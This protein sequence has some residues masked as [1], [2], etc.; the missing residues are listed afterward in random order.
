MRA[1]PQLTTYFEIQESINRLTELL[2]NSTMELSD[3]AMKELMSKLDAE[4]ERL[5]KEAHGNR[6]ISQITSGS[7]AG[8]WTAHVNGKCIRRKT[9]EQFIDAMFEAYYPEGVTSRITFGECFEQMLDYRRTKAKVAEL[10]V[11]H[12]QSDYTKY[13]KGTDL[14]RKLIRE[15]KPRDIIH[16]VDD[17]TGM[18]P[19]TKDWKLTKKQFTN[20]KT[21]LSKTLEY[22]MTEEIIDTNPIAGLKFGDIQ[23]KLEK[24]TEEE[25]YDS[26][27]RTKIL[28]YLNSLPEQTNYQLDIHF[29]FCT[30]CR[31]GEVKG[32]RWK[33]I[34]LGEDGYYIHICREVVDRAVGGKNRVQV[35]VSH[36]KGNKETGIRDMP[37]SDEAIKVLRMAEE[38]N[39]DHTDEDLIFPNKSGGYFM[40]NRFNENLKKICEAVGVKYRSSHKMRF[41]GIAACAETT[42]DI[43]VTQRIAGHSNLGMTE[44]YANKGRRARKLV[45]PAN[46]DVILGSPRAQ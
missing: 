16:F 45:R 40:T 34:V 18:D 32:L 41:Y 1:T 26:E 28:N 43:L 39:P 33:D 27:D 42:E 17:I 30:I 9:Y 24:S 36:T 31:I 4:K 19:N 5:V 2:C 20:L 11:T 3:A 44:Y 22:A 21:V 37:L 15:I 46:W 10:T 12:Y 35:E 14:D 38:R 25:Y 29:M 23:F 7:R 13:V 6:K 8:E